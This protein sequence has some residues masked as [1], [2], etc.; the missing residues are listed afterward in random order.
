M[1]GRILLVMSFLPKYVNV[2][3]MFT[4]KMSSG[5]M[6]MFVTREI[7]RALNVRSNFVLENLSLVCNSWV[8]FLKKKKTL[9]MIS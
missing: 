5:E 8:V 1:V 7:R 3:I 4:M 9:Y 6:I 2:F